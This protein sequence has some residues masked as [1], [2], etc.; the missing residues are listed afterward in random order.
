MR[1][2]LM[3]ARELEQGWTP[4][5]LWMQ[6]A[7]LLPG[8]AIGVIAM[9]AVVNA[10]KGT[11]PPLDEMSPSEAVAAIHA[12]ADY[13]KS[14]EEPW[15]T[16]SATYYGSPYDDGKRR[17]CADG[18]TV[19]TSDGLFCATRL[20]PLGSI[21][22]VRRGKVTLRLKVADTQA[23]RFGHLIDLPT[24]TWAK[25]GAKY[26]TGKVRVEWRVAK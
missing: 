22:E 18:K 5:P 19:Y 16:T 26:S 3:T 15:R 14:F 25:L 17:L 10:V 24:K 12:R 21:I 9:L 20:V 1:R 13:P 23:K 11:L 6:A 2:D 4:A 7:L 8:A